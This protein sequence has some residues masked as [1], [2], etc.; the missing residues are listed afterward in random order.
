[1]VSLKLFI[2]LSK[3]NLRY[4]NNSESSD[5]YSVKRIQDAILALHLMAILQGDP[6][7]K[8]W[9]SAPAGVFATTLF[10]TKSMCMTQRRQYCFIST[11]EVNTF[12]TA[13][14]ITKFSRL[15]KLVSSTL[16][17]FLQT[18]HNHYFHSWPMRSYISHFIQNNK[19]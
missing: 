1:M 8:S 5:F 11:K 6:H 4:L 17:Q 16:I 19:Q 13:Y 3:N 15:L 9:K 7:L 14:N 18:F 2:L 12:L 10:V